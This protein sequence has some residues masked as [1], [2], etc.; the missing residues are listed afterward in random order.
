MSVVKTWHFNSVHDTRFTKK[1][2]HILRLMLKLSE[3]SSEKLRELL[4]KEA[5]QDLRQSWDLRVP[6]TVLIIQSIPKLLTCLYSL[7]LPATT[8][9]YH[10]AGN[11]IRERKKSQE[12]EMEK[13]SKDW[14]VICTRTESSSSRDNVWFCFLLSAKETSEK[15]Y[16]AAGGSIFTFSDLIGRSL[17]NR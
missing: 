6:D 9:C 7:L 14:A 4:I 11:F 10:F 13:C 12:H 5:S 17:F 8:A 2:D 16:C 15:T 3:K 1:T